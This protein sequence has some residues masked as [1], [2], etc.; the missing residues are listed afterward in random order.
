[1]DNAQQ[2][3]YVPRKLLETLFG[4]ERGASDAR[5]LELFYARSSD[6]FSGACRQYVRGSGETVQLQAA[7]FDAAEK[8]RRRSVAHAMARQAA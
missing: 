3:F 2:R 6:I 7:D 4:L 5:Q 8:D 1:M